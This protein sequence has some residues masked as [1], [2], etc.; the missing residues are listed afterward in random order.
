MPDRR[1]ARSSA[2]RPSA[3]PRRSVQICATILAT[4]L[5]CLIS[6]GPAVAAPGSDQTGTDDAV[7]DSFLQLSIDS[8]TPS[9]VT[10]SGSSTVTVS[11]HVDNV[12]DRMLHDL[13]VRLE[14]GDP[15]R[16]ANGLRS[17]LVTMPD[18]ATVATPFRGLSDDLAPGKSAR[19]T[20]TAPLSG[21]DGLDIQ[22]TGVFP[23][24]VNVNGLPDYGNPAKLA[25]SRTLLPVLSLPPDRTRAA[26]YVGPTV[27]DTA[28]DTDLGPDGSVSAN[29]SSP[30][31]LTMLWPLAAPPQLTPGV[32]GGNTEPVRLVG[33]DLAR[34]L[35]PGGRLSTLLEAA[36]SV[37]GD[38]ASADGGNDD[39]G[40]DGSGEAANDSA[41]NTASS[42][43]TSGNG[44]AQP[45]ASASASPGE[46]TGDAP[47]T[48]APEAS[49]LQQS[50]CLAVDPDL[51]VT[52]RAMSLGYLVSDDPLDPLSATTTGTGQAAAGQ[53]LNELRELAARTC[54]V[55][56][57][58]A[59]ADLTSLARI[60]NP[61][62]T[63][64]A[65]STP[66]GV[67]DA[68][69]GVRSVRG[70]TVPALGALDATGAGVLTGESIHGAVTSTSSVDP[71]RNAG[72]GRYRI[73]D[74][75]VQTAEAPVTAALAA[76]GAAPT[77]PPLAPQ[78]QRVALDDESAVS[79]RQA[80]VAAL[81]YPSIAAPAPASDDAPPTPMPVAG[82]SAFVVPPTYWAPSADDTNALLTTATLLLE[83]G[84]AAPGPLPDVVRDMDTA[85]DDAR[86]VA[87]PGVGPLS[88]LGASVQSPVTGTMQAHAELSWQ[89]QASLMR[90]ADVAASPERY[91]APL[92]EDLLRAIR[93]PNTSSAGE[94]AD[95]RSQRDGRV[96]AVGSTLQR[97]RNAVTILDPGG[98]YTLASERSPLLLVVRNDLSLPIRVR[99]NVAAPSDLDVGDIGVIEIPAR[100][101]RQIQLPTRAGTSEAITVTMSLETSSGVP[102]GSPIRLSV[103]SNAYGKTLFW[104]TIVAGVALVLLTARRLWHRFRGEPDPADEDRPDP[105]EHARMLAGST[106]QQRRRTLQQEDGALETEHTGPEHTGPEH[107]E[108]ETTGAEPT[109]S[110]RDRT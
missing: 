109:E 14:R 49:K 42:P 7:P 73:G 96:T 102:I 56:L 48:P 41:D 39:D 33:D 2:C 89:L 100:G 40:N 108:P 4:L 3:S 20:I 81:A 23:I 5:I 32:L 12:G 70:I 91:M 99:M 54:V 98:R 85:D 75:R 17:D 29:L 107:A 82:R 66:A 13:T 65:L 79:R 26:D 50:M 92:R 60:D 61:G 51:L 11:G 88:T 106:Y 43:A 105:D 87:P 64:A 35:A 57:P 30:S 27:D 90:S 63:T 10:S 55:A 1:P 38:S 95:I 62:L 6:A 9:M 72:T 78:S 28:E 52:V 22:R 68:I 110:D 58:F 36:R 74:L 47:S 67:I 77:T 53:W 45:P 94:R 83:S 104:I 80:A 93:T 34:S 15:V 97:M 71:R 44:A 16:T 103:H 46:S 101:T 86:F 59:Q 37:A 69:L 84:A 21:S 19:F 31:R 25:E 18:P 8:M 76:L 24:Q